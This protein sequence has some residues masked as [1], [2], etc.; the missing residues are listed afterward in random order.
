MR[1]SFLV[2]WAP[3]PFVTFPLI[4]MTAFDVKYYVAYQF[5]CIGFQASLADEIW[6]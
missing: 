6:N 3:C 2:T 4:N 5:I 1:M